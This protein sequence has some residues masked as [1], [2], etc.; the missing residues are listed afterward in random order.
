FPSRPRCA[1]GSDAVKHIGGLTP[2]HDGEI[3]PRFQDDPQGLVDRF[4]IE[5]LTIAVTQS[6][7][8]ET[9]GTLYKSARR[10][11]WT[12][13]VTCSASRADASG[14]RARTIASSLSKGG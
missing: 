6:M 13:A 10:S 5:R 3:L 4:G 1:A 11:S 9:P 12:I 2:P 7:V 8:S 14:A